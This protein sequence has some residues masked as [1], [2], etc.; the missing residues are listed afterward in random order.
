[1]SFAEISKAF[2]AMG[3]K[4]QEEPKVLP[5]I[6]ESFCGFKVTKWGDEIFPRSKVRKEMKRGYGSAY[7]EYDLIFPML[8]SDRLIRMLVY[9]KTAKPSMGLGFRV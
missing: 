8:E 5:L 2:S 1:M 4:F 7:R 6:E 3:A 9:P